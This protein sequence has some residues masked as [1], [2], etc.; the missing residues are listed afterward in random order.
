MLP[1]P[2]SLIWLCVLVVLAAAIVTLVLRHDWW[3][4]GGPIDYWKL[5]EDSISHALMLAMLSAATLQIVSRYFLAG[6]IPEDYVDYFLFPWTEEF[7]RLVML[8]LAM[9][10]AAAIQRGDDHISMTVVFDLLPAAA[11]RWVRIFGDVVTIAVLVPVTWFG[12]VTARSLD[13]MNT[14]ELGFPISVF[15]YPIPMVGALMIVHSFGLIYRRWHN[16]PIKSNFE[17]E[18]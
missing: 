4:V 17:L 3:P 16:L 9:V 15:A 14:I 5:F 7:A 6:L 2:D 12:W 8:W 11:K 18:I 13:I 10:G 1:I